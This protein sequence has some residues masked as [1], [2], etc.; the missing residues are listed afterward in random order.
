M[1]NR[2]N[3]YAGYK[4]YMMAIN[5]YRKAIEINPKIADAYKYQGIL[6]IDM[7]KLDLAL[8][9]FDKAIKIKPD[10]DA[11]YYRG[12]V[13]YMKKDSKGACADLKSAVALG[14]EEA[15]SKISGMCVE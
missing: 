4:K 14:H 9:D 2:G 12:A 13:K 5:D 7:N 15:K 6:Y 1:L 10:G 3:A 11:Y 8:E